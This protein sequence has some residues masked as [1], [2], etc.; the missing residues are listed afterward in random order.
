MSTV[1]FLDIDAS[2][3]ST[4]CPVLLPLGAPTIAPIIS[5]SMGLFVP[6]F[7]FVVALFYHMFHMWSGENAEGLYSA[8]ASRPYAPAAAAAAAAGSSKSAGLP[9][10]QQPYLRFAAPPSLFSRGPPPA[11]MGPQPSLRGGATTSFFGGQ[12]LY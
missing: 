6:F 12:P 11:M 8:S 9:P 5:A 10:R 7:V 4:A 3:W 1:L 2:T